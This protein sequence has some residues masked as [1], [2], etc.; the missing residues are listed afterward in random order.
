M[1]RVVKFTSGKGQARAREARRGG[2]TGV[3]EPS[4]KAC[5]VAGGLRELMPG[6]PG[7]AF[8]KR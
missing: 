8:W 7:R 6:E 5:A 4:F 3:Q 2:A 1:V